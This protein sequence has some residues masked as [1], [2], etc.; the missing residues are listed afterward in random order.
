MTKNPRDHREWSNFDVQDDPQ[1][2]LA[3]QKAL[4]EAQEKA[5]KQ[6]RLERERLDFVGPMIDRGVPED[7]AQRGWEDYLL[8]TATND[9]EQVAQRER[10][11]I[12]SV[13]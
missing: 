12:S 13:L 6:S 4:R 1:G 7:I 10:R 2:Y 5:E 3:A 9:A 11:R 8:M